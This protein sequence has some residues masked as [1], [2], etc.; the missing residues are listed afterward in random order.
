MSS[1]E[2]T[3]DSTQTA[4]NQRAES[5]KERKIDLKA[6]KTLSIIAFAASLSG[7]LLIALPFV[8]LLGLILGLGG[9]ILGWMMRK[10][11]KKKIWAKLAIGLGAL[12]LVLFLTTLAL[13]IF[14]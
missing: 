1:S 4:F 12:C 5:Q 10:R 7:V 14:V 8:S 6:P 13:V 11:V 9:L 3:I 2:M